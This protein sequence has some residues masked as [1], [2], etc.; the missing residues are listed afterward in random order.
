MLFGFS[1]MDSATP[2]GRSTSWMAGAPCNGYRSLLF[3]C[4]AMFSMTGSVSADGLPPK[5][6]SASRGTA[7]IRFARLPASFLPRLVHF[8]GHRRASLLPEDSGSGCAWGDYDG[9]G[10]DDMFLCNS[11]GSSH[12]PWSLRTRSSWR[13][14]Q[15]DRRVRQWRGRCVSAVRFEQPPGCQRRRRGHTD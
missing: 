6:P 1:Q 3:F 4:G 15:G 2:T 13:V 10:D 8:N 12:R 14:Y 5:D 7:R 11:N 9:D